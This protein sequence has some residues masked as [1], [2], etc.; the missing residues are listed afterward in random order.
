[1]NVNLSAHQLDDDRLVDD[2]IAAINE[3]GIH[4]SQLVLEINES[5][6]MQDT[7]TTT[8]ERL[9]ALKAVGVRLAI[10]AS[11]RATR[12]SATSSDCRST[13]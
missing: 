3:A 2:V 13:R 9:L 5:V 12:R 4:P 1:M 7:G 8:A 10:D 6:V 11:E